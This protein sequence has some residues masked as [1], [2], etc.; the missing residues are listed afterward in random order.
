[1]LSAEGGTQPVW[2]RDGKE[3]FFVSPEG[4]LMAAQ[5]TWRGGAIEIGRID[6]LFDGVLTARGYQWDVSADGQKFIRWEQ[7][8]STRSSPLTLVQNWTG[9]L[10]K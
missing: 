1:M 3:L 5:V 9:L 10:S 4:R 6:G 7:T 8:D 2:R